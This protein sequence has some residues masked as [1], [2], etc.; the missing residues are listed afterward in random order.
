MM[1]RS[2]LLFVR[3]CDGSNYRREGLTE[4]VGLYEGDAAGYFGKH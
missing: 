1:V 4:G 3:L 2:S